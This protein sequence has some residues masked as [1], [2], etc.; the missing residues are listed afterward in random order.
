HIAVRVTGEKAK[1]ST[2][3]MVGVDALE[4]VFR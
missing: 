3:T 4:V 1:Q 2:G